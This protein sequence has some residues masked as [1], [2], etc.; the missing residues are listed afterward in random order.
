ML[1]EYQLQFLEGIL[2]WEQDKLQTLESCA[3]IQYG[4]RNPIDLICFPGRKAKR[5]KKF[6]ELQ[7]NYFRI[8]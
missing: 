5:E 2:I 3:R 1:L 4:A 8:I 6:I 7:V